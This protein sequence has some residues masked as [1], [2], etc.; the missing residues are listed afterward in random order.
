MKYTE[1][2]RVLEC[3][4][5]YKDTIFKLAYSYCKDKGQAEDAFQEVFYKFMKRN[6]QFRDR[7]HEKAWFI[8]TTI[9]VCKDILKSKWSR[10]VVQL[11]EWDG[12]HA[13]QDGSGDIFDELR[14]AILSLPEKYRVPIHLYYYEEYT[15]REIAQI[16]HRSESAVQTQLQ[17]GREKLKQKMERSDKYEIESRYLQRSHG[18]C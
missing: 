4:Q 11:E 5:A 10:M 13:F 3:Y 14:E 15:V 7:E 18:E 8:R 2:S 12:D 16:L 17:R 6:P 9:N 1:E